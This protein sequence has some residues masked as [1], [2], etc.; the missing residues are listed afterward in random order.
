MLYEVITENIQR[1]NLN[2]VEEADAYYRLMSEFGLTQ[3]QVSEKV[4]KSRPAV[5]NFLRLRNLPPEIKDSLADGRLTTGHAKVL[6][7]V[8][9]I[10]LQRELW[11][12]ILEKNL[13]VLV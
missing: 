12:M 10:A 11:R 1:A 7:G 2:P 5:A 3:E 13:S 8:E 9:P 4:G 6:L